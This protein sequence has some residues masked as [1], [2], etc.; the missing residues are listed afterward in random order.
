MGVSKVKFTLFQF[1]ALQATVLPGKVLKVYQLRAGRGFV[2]RFLPGRES[3]ANEEQVTGY[4]V[5]LV[6]PLSP[7]TAGSGPD[8]VKA[9]LFRAR[10]LLLQILKTNENEY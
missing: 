3:P 10:D 6:W 2:V 1:V 5:I 8:P 9:K 4:Q 7:A